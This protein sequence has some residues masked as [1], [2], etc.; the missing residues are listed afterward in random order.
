M[1]QTLATC[2]VYGTIFDVFGVPVEGAIVG[3]MSVYKNGSLVLIGT[4]EVSTDVDGYFTMDLPRGPNCVAILYANTPGL[5]ISALGTPTAIPDADSAELAAI[6]GDFELW[7]EV[8][9][10]IPGGASIGTPIGG[11][12]PQAILFIDSGGGLGQDPPKLMYD[13]A[14]VLLPADPTLPLHA[15]TRQ[16]V[17][18]HGATP[19]GVGTE[20]QYRLNATTLGAIPLSGLGTIYG[21]PAL[22][23]PTVKIL[24][25]SGNGGLLFLDAAVTGQAGFGISSPAL[26]PLSI[27]YAIHAPGSE[28]YLYFGRSGG[29]GYV[30]QFMS[31]YTGATG[32]EDVRR[33]YVASNGAVV[34]NRQSQADQGSALTVDQNGNTAF[35]KA[36]QC[37]GI[38]EMSADP[39]TPLGI[40]TKQFVEAHG[41][42]PAGSATEL[43]YRLTATT[44]GAVPGSSYV[45]ADP[46][47][48]SL[49]TVSVSGAFR[50]RASTS[51]TAVIGIDGSNCWIVAGDPFSG[52]LP[53][54]VFQCFHNG[55]QPSGSSYLY[56]GRGTIGRYIVPYYISFYTGATGT[57]DVRRLFISPNG[58]IVTNQQ[59]LADATAALTVNASGN[60]TFAKAL[61]INGN[62]DMAT[63][64]AYRCLFGS[65]N[66]SNMLYI[67]G[68][69]NFV[70]IG[71]ETDYSGGIGGSVVVYACGTG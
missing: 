39:T 27:F 63:N 44:F 54:S 58:S 8:P 13:G 37:N 49:P 16:Y 48:Q 29:Q 1:P 65:G 71:P 59:G 55:T 28:R 24:D 3:C 20:I 69:A 2:E 35:A 46:M 33:M 50:V 26:A 17:D 60:A 56:I 38:G 34:I 18:A 36:F 12:T 14:G 53:M 47:F 5:N 22:T 70:H 11:G 31:F 25:A 41:A 64:S 68:S 9:I 23:L 32:T 45:A 42:T 43:Q 10:A 15:A 61:Q 57:E 67:D 62:A 6:I 19:A 51:N 7:N 66:A 21:G 40:A 4:K 52:A 30:P